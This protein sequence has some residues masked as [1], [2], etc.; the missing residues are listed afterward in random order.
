[1]KAKIAFFVFTAL[2]TVLFASFQTLTKEATIDDKTLLDIVAGYD[3]LPLFNYTVKMAA[4]DTRPYNPND[5]VVY[6]PTTIFK[7]RCMDSTAHGGKIFRLRVK[8]DSNYAYDL[9]QPDGQTIVMATYNYTQSSKTL[10]DGKS[11]R[12][13]DSTH[14]IP[15][16]AGNF[17]VLYKSNAKA[18]KTD[19][20]WMYGVV[21]GDGKRVISKGLLANCMGCHSQSKTDCMLGAK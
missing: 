12:L 21:S 8:D 3:K 11:L 14:L 7:S 4:V 20:G 1:M 18:Y 13:N 19:N 6:P 5:P 2:C 10:G 9:T 17:F 15:T 16:T